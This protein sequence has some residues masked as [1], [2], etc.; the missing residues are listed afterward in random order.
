ME[1]ENTTTTEARAIFQ[2]AEDRARTNGNED[3]ASALQ[4]AKEYFTNPT[5]RRSLEDY[6]FE[7]TYK[8]VRDDR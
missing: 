1:S 2:Y 6:L 4:L 7:R 8:G 5:F 3:S